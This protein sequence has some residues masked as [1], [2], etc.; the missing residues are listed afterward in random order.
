ML[1]LQ[2]AQVGYY[3]VAIT[4]RF[5]RGLQSLPAVIEIG[6]VPGVQSQEKLEDWLA[7]TNSGGTFRKGMQAA[8]SGTAG[9][10][11]VYA[12]TVDQQIVNNNISTDS[13]VYCGVLGRGTL[14]IVLK[15]MD[16]GTM[17]INTAGSSVNTMLL[18]KR[19]I[20]VNNNMTVVACAVTA[21]GQQYARV[22]FPAIAG[23]YYYV[24]VDGL[25]NA[26]GVLNIN[27]A[28]GQPPRIATP[29][30]EI[31]ATNGQNL[32]VQVKVSN[33]IPAASIQ[34]LLNEAPVE[35]G[36]NATL[37]LTD[38]QP[39]ACGVYAVQV[40]NAIGQAKSP[41]AR[42]N[43]VT[44]ISRNGFDAGPEQWG[45]GTSL[46][47]SNYTSV[48]IWQTGGWLVASGQQKDQRWW[49]RAPQGFLGRPAS[50]YAGWLEFSLKAGVK[51]TNRVVVRLRSAAL[52]LQYLCAASVETNWTTF[53][54]PLQE[55]VGWQ[56]EQ[57][58][59]ASA[60]EFE[61][62]FTS[63]A[64]LQL[65][66]VFQAGSDQM[67]LDDVRFWRFVGP[68]M[69]IAASSNGMMRIAW[70]DTGRKYVLSMSTLLTPNSWTTS[71]PV[72]S[73]VVSNGWNQVILPSQPG[74]NFFRLSAE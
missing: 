8:A 74:G 44:S 73:R 68:Q 72:I 63:G 28:L 17:V 7:L 25:N 71:F 16:N 11:L 2:P 53:R 3:S 41:I 55:G 6:A 32:S 45:W 18:V 48:A 15:P 65:E 64:E 36:T 21:P 26:R 24:C 57:G 4:N 61:Q 19:P 52:S 39:F 33:A 35:S 46:Q 34:W 40:T 50:S 49:W 13:Q 5:G 66:G 67:K 51:G 42:V 30:S 56:T 62:V 59:T 9:P 43:S 1:N 60:L 70:P 38:F 14:W 10:L 37:T 47:G 54:V 27:Y 20:D 58:A 31:L 22:E 12:G 23:T 69:Q 29:Y